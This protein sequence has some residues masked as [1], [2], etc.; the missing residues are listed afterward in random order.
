MRI[1]E[2]NSQFE[3]IVTRLLDMNF[4]LPIKN[5]SQILDHKELA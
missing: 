1:N 2:K 5:V 3:I 4:I